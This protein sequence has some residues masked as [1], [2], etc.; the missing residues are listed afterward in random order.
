MNSRNK[1]EEGFTVVELIV[2]MS[3]FAV[4]LTI[5]VGV[6]VKTIRTQRT[7]VHRMEV[8]D[9]AGAVLEQIT[10]EVRTGYDFCPA[11]FAGGDK[12]N[13]PGGTSL[14]ADSLT[15]TNHDGDSVTYALNNGAVTR[16]GNEL[17]APDVEIDNL[18]FIVWQDYV[19]NPWRV[20]ILMGVGSEK[21]ES[22]QFIDLQTTVSSRVLPREAPNAPQEIINTCE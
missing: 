15:F 16:D 18:K 19:C 11:E 5:S 1:R 3:I 12:C 6:F 10:R 14:E 4:F 2:A 20:T 7:L 13:L 21:V 22:G 17:S 9:N 8:N